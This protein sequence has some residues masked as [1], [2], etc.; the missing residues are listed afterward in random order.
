MVGAVGAP[1]R[2]L[3]SLSERGQPQISWHLT[4]AQGLPRPQSREI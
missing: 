2:V 1:H 4:E 3:R